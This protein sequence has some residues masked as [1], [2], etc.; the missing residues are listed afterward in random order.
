MNKVILFQN[1]CESCIQNKLDS[2]NIEGYKFVRGVP[3]NKE[4]VFYYKGNY[5]DEDDLTETFF[6][7]G[8]EESGAK[9]SMSGKR[10]SKEK[11]INW[12]N[13][14]DKEIK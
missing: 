2:I 6:E 7:Q 4:N 10:Y 13:S 1:G 3:V 5:I 8:V 9:W 11:I 14:I 12:L